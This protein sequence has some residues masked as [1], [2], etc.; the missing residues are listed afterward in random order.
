[1]EELVVGMSELTVTNGPSRLVSRGIG[2]C[3]VL[4]LYD[5]KNQIAGMAHSVLPTNSTKNT[6]KSA[7]YS[8][9]AVDLLVEQLIRKGADKKSLVAKIAGGADM[10]PSIMKSATGS[11]GDKNIFIIK[12][13]L[14]KENI[15]LISEDVG[16]THGRNVIFDILTGI[17]EVTIRI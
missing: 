10:F 14:L 4:V 13:K 15:K 8:D 16:G 2:S 11:I 5:S 3:I 9:E 6:Q 7:K 17:M 1:M 12:E